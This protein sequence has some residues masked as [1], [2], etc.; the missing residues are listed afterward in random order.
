MERLNLKAAVVAIQLNAK[1]VTD[2]PHFTM[3]GVKTLWYK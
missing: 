1:I 3:L 2:D